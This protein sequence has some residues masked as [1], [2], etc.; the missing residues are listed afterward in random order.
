MRK[1]IFQMMVTLDGFYEGLNGDIDWHNVDKEFNEYAIDLLNSI[2]ILLFGRKTY[3]MMAGYWPTPDA[4]KNSPVIAG[5]MNSLSKIA[6]SRTLTTV[7][8]ENTRLVK[9]NIPEEMAKLKRLPGKDIAI[10]GSSDLALTFIEHGLIDEY[11]I[12]IN[13]VVLGAGKPLFLGIKT[14]LNLE[15]AKRRVFKSGNVLGYY[16]PAR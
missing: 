4:V 10:F 8:W 14:K 12:M 15:L 9:D 1:V 13:P 11:R 7:E 5:K 3:Q 16:E 2:D 6:F